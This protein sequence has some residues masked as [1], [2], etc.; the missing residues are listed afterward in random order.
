MTYQVVLIHSDEGYAVSCPALPGCH[1]QGET[2]SEALDNIRDAIREWLAAQVE[3]P[4]TV[5]V[6]EVTVS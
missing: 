4:D 3:A 2:E 1:S 5:D 6:R